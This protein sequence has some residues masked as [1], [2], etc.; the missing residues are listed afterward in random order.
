VSP[1]QRVCRA[2][3]I[4]VLGAFA[5]VTGGWGEFQRELKAGTLFQDAP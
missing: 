3:L 5:V 4:V 2:L 1:A